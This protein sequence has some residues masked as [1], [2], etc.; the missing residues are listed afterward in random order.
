MIKGI[1]IINPDEVE[2][3][4]YNKC[5]DYAIEKGYNHIQITGPIHD[6]IKGNVDGM[7]LNKKY[8][9][10]N[11]EKDIEYVKLCQEVI[12]EGLK[13]SKNAGIKTYMWHHELNLPDGFSER[14][15]E[16]KN[17]NGD[18]ELTHPQVKDYL[19]NKIKDFYEQYP[20]MDGIVLTLHETKTPILKLKNQRLSVNE[21]IKYITGILYETS[22]QLGKE[23]IVR[24]FA[25]LE[26]DQE[27]ML[28]AYSEISK[29]MV[30]MDKW[31]K[32]DWS[33]VLPHND[34]FKKITK[35]PFI[36]EGDIFGEYFGLGKIPVMLEQHLKDKVEYC[37]SFNHGGYV[38]RIDRDY[39]NAFN[40]VNEVNLEIMHALLNGEDVSQAIDKFYS[41]MYGKAGKEIKEIM[42]Q[43]EEIQKEIFYANGY[44]FVQGSFF[45]DIN[46]AKNHFFFEIMKENYSLSSNEWFVP[47]GWK[48]KSISSIFAEKEHALELSQQFL[49]KI[50]SL[51]DSIPTKN[52]D[53]ILIKFKNLNYI[54]HL[55]LNLTK[56]VY[57]YTR[58]FETYDE[59]L[60]DLLNNSIENINTINAQGYSELKEQFYNAPSS[61]SIINSP[62][63]IATSFA[64]LPAHFALEKTINEKLKS[65]PK[66]I[67]YVIC[68]GCTESH[69][70]QKEVN[71]S[72]TLLTNDNI[73]RVPGNNK[74]AQW[75]SI[76]AHGWFSYLVKVKPNQ[77]NKISI[78]ATSPTNHLSM[79]VTIGDKV[80]NIDKSISCPTT[81]TF[82]HLSAQSEVRV[83]IDRV[84]QHTPLISLITVE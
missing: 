28:K 1:S 63:R 32:F 68:G 60:I 25:S 55:W 49:N 47:V 2:R 41:K 67:D 74:G 73:Y 37:N 16:I 24:P 31:T 20:D 51:K 14:Y 12:N 5:I 35:N 84:N 39:N 9:D 78:T 70:L 42:T 30:I 7:T 64:N 83:R 13:R 81:L 61:K 75:S 8:S 33:L 3:E 26:K 65:N 6:M 69:N 23:V 46:H 72:D 43:T 40:S 44:Y 52:Y 71:F 59:Q 66:L 15:P 56:A 11:G 38:L 45:P 79:T 62:Q 54:A 48:R 57:A 82:D 50:I 27:D 22:K 34:F 53:N 58:Y 17:A 18:I 4:Y 80:Y 21:R 36:I 29:D 10:F 76:N 77:Q 19:E